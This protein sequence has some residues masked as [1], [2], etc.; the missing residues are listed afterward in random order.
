MFVPNFE[1]ISRVT[2][3]LEPKNNCP[4]KFGVKSRLSQKRLKYGKKYFTWL[5][6]VRYPFILTNPL[7]ATISFFALFF[8]IF[9]LNLVRSSP[10]KPQ[11]IES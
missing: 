1:A 8:F 4:Q 2:L 10:P 3:V 11:T 6:A 7:L 9:F 5:N